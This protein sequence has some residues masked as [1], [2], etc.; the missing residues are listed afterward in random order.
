M[1]ETQDTAPP[2][3]AQVKLRI[4]MEMRRR[5]KAQAALNTRTL[6]SEIVH[7][8]RLAMKPSNGQGAQA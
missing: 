5:L 6:S 3:D 1:T 8:L 7:I 4:P 2:S